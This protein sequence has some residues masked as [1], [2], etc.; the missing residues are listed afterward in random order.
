MRMSEIISLGA[1]AALTLAA[2]IIGRFAAATAEEEML[3]AA[4]KQLTSIGFQHLTLEADGLVLAVSGRVRSEAERAAALTRLRRTPGLSTLYDNVVVIAPLADLRPSLLILEKDADSLTLSGEAPSA[5]ARDLLA[6]RAAVAHPDR[7]VVNLMKAQEGRPSEAW[8]AAADAALEALRLVDI[9]R[10]AVER[11]RLRLDGAAAEA[12]ASARIEEKLRAALGPD[13]AVEVAVN[14]PPPLLSPYRFAARKQSG[15]LEILA[16]AAPDAAQRSVILGAIRG[17]GESPAPGQEPRCQIAHGAP[18]EAWVAAVTRG[19]KALAR[20]EEGEI[21]IAD[22]RI[23]LRGFAP[24]GAHLENLR[25]AAASDWP[26]AYQLKTDI[27]GPVAV[28]APFSMT[29]LRRPGATTLSGDT[30][31]LERAEAWAKTLDAANRLTLARGAPEGWIEAADA[32]VAELARLPIGAATI[33][34]RRILLAAPGDASVRAQIRDRLRRALPPGYEA[35]VAEAEA[36]GPIQASAKSPAGDAPI[37]RSSYSFTASRD[38]EGVVQVGGVIGDPTTRSVVLAYAKAKLGGDALT[39]TMALA[40]DGVAPAGWQRA[41]FAVIEA[42]AELEAGEAGAE[43]GAV[44]LRG[45]TSAADTARRA[46]T[47]LEQKAPPEFARFSTLRVREPRPV[48]PTLGAPLPPQECLSD[49]N[50]RVTEE[51]I[52]FAV[53]SATIEDASLGVL[54]ALAE[55]MARCPDVK[56]EVGGHTDSSGRAEANKRLS[57]RRAE[58]V[59]LSL[60][61]R[62]VERARLVSVGYGADEPVADNDS[63]AGRAQNRRIAFKLL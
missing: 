5:E 6:A 46:R 31:T 45:Q 36:T 16:C 34:D 60:T 33:K 27:L 59:R 15:R 43:P 58:A 1:L 48:D 62:G 38:R 37:D 41:V 29:A 50:K 23:R 57:E 18:N 14:A 9:G 52:L 51:P 17:L 42:L 19:A 26:K 2:L 28:A 4:E 35:E 10:A 13:F 25:L 22:N 39:D 20:L 8:S 30:P 49:L 47:H 63:E 7:A 32:A 44:Y 21:E 12:G 55:T 56:I 53:N 3:A 54:D 40:D 24:E 11:N 61:A